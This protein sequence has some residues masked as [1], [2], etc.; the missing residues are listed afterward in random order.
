MATVEKIVVITRRTALEELI[1]RHSSRGQARFYIES[2]GA[3]FGEYEAAH[4][5]Y[6]AAEKS[7]KAD[8]PRGVRVQ[9]I[10][11]DFLPTFTFGASDLVVTIGADGLVV[12][13]AKYLDAQSL[14]AFNPDPT[15]IDGVLVPFPIWQAKWVLE[16]AAQGQGSVEK[17]TMAQ[18]SLNDG[19]TLLALND[20]FIGRRGHASARYRLI[21]GRESEEQSSS[22]VIVSTGAGSTGW[23][24]SVLTGAGRILEDFAPTPEVQ[25]ASQAAQNDFRFGWSEQKLQFSVREPFVSKTSGARLVFGEIAGRGALEIVSLMPQDGVIFSD[26]IESDALEFNSGA[27]AHIAVASRALHLVTQV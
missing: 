10:E 18:A 27:I 20:L 12:N 23:L 24:R 15:R 17:L 3:S 7:L 5:A 6:K 22:G 13:A 21:I 2:R 1:E 14:L 8:L 9:W 25:S 16:R 11:R 4:N 26:G 19:Q